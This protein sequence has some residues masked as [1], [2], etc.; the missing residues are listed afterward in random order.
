MKGFQ[1]PVGKLRVYTE[2]FGYAL[3]LLIIVTFVE[4]GISK[5]HAATAGRPFPLVGN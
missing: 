4:V 1:S 3:G 2:A 5:A